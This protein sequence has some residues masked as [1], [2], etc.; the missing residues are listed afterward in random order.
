M[1]G[2]NLEKTF[3][4][5]NKL[6]AVRLETILWR[7]KRTEKYLNK[8]RNDLL[9]R[10]LTMR[11]TWYTGSNFNNGVCFGFSVLSVHKIWM[12]WL[13]FDEILLIHFSH[14]STDPAEKQINLDFFFFLLQ[15]SWQ[16]CLGDSR[17]LGVCRKTCSGI[18]MMKWIFCA[19]CRHMKLWMESC[20]IS[21]H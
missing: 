4:H 2:N 14:I 1:S 9:V 8:Y 3:F 11:Q 20:L 15:K 19:T 10:I 5:S 13:L 6:S 12:K 18:N 16:N 7:Q 17:R 21:I